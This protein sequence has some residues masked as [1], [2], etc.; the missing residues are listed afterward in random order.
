MQ[1]P[2]RL[3][4]LCSIYILVLCLLITYQHTQFL[5]TLTN[6][7]QCTIWNCHSKTV[8]YQVNSENTINTFS[9]DNLPWS[10]V[11]VNSCSSLCYNPRFNNRGWLMS[12]AEVSW[13]RPIL[14]MN[15]D[16][17]HSYW[18]TVITS[19]LTDE[20]SS[21]SKVLLDWFMTLPY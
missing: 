2:L 10:C 3:H 21:T 9:Q 12:V 19:T 11:C 5:R 13:S 17:V 8:S 6:L 4:K 16:H 1:A 15:A 7:E 14:L 20:R 18:R